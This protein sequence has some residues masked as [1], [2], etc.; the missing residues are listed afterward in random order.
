METRIYHNGAASAQMCKVRA[1]ALSFQALSSRTIR[2]FSFAR[3]FA[4]VSEW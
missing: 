1:M 4:E 3:A 2:S